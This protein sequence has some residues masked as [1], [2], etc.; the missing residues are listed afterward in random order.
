MPTAL[1]DTQPPPVILDL[2]NKPLHPSPDS[3]PRSP[4]PSSTSS[5]SSTDPLIAQVIAGLRGTSEHV[6]PGQ[7]SEDRKFAYKRSIPTMTLYSQ[8]GLEIYED[9]TNTKVRPFPSLP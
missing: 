3:P 6:V 4:S 7:T 9:I 1:T 5:D 2:R 8:R